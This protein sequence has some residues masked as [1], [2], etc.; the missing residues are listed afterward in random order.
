MSQFIKEN[1]PTI[2]FNQIA[3]SS[4]IGTNIGI[5]QI[6]SVVDQNLERLRT[7]TNKNIINGGL[8]DENIKTGGIGSVSTN[9]DGFDVEQVGV[10]TTSVNLNNEG[11]V[12]A[13]KVLVNGS[14]TTLVPNKYVYI[15][16]KENWRYTNSATAYSVDKNLGL[17]I[18]TNPDFT[19]VI[20]AKEV[21]D[22]ALS[23]PDAQAIWATGSSDILVRCLLPSASTYYYRITTRASGND[24]VVFE[25]KESTIVGWFN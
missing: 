1:L 7:L 10:V 6:I 5:N 3:T 21:K 25:S 13:T 14:F 2:A 22:Q 4:T 19:G 23:N 9:L 11:P 15:Y 20:K 17:E 8:S 18:S 16:G 24:T 12:P